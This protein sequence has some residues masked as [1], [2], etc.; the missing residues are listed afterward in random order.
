MRNRADKDMRH[1]KFCA[2][3]CVAA[4]YVPIHIDAIAMVLKCTRNPV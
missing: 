3:S 2:V 1:T 4:R